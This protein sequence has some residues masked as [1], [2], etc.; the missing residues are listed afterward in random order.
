M[1]MPV[2]PNP[3]NAPSAPKAIEP[4]MIVA[5]DV[6]VDPMLAQLLPRV[7]AEQFQCVPIEMNGEVLTVAMMD[8]GDVLLI[9]DAAFTVRCLGTICASKAVPAGSAK[10]RAIPAI[11]TTR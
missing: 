4:A 3:P 10:P 9:Q 7:A 8:P 1:S 2:V 11:K 6:H 5:A